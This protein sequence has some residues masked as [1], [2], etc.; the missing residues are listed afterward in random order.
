MQ[1]TKQLLDYS[2]T[3]PN[4]LINFRAS[5]MVLTGHSDVSY[6]SEYGTRIRRGGN[7][8]VTDES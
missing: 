2:A 6:L 3:H 7:F 1:K 5:D 4:A 8:F